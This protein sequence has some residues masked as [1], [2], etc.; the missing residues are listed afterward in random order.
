MRFCR[1][2]AHKGRPGL[3]LC[4]VIAVLVLL[5][6]AV[7]FAGEGPL[8]LKAPGLRLRK[9]PSVVIPADYLYANRALHLPH[10]RNAAGKPARGWAHKYIPTRRFHSDQSAWIYYRRHDLGQ[11]VRLAD[12]Q[13]IGGLCIWPGG[14]FI[15]IESFQGSAP[16]RQAANPLKIEAMSKAGQNSPPYDKDF[17]AAQWSYAGFTAGGDPALDDAKVRQCHQCHAIAFRLTGDSV[18]T[19]L[20]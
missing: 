14:S 17:F 10:Y 19:R 2:A 16:R 6:W 3:G 15:V 11:V 9:D 20:P 13:D 1:I 8:Y 18:F 5:A 7:L 4:G 12:G